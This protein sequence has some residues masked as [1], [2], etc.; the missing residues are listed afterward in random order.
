MIIKSTIP[1]GFTRDIKERL[2][3]DNCTFSLLSSCVKAVRCTTTCTHRV[4][5]LVRRS[6]RAERFC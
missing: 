3:I 4:L 1:V 5:S 2:G 6:A